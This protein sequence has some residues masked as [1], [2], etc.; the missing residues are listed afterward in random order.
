MSFPSSSK[1]ALSNKGNLAK[2]TQQLGGSEPSFS[3]SRFCGSGWEIKGKE[4]FA[5]GLE[6]RRERE[7]EQLLSCSLTP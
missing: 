4:C 3:L 6:S 7:A 5:K 2:S 1:Q